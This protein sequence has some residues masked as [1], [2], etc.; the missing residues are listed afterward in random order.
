M[1][2]MTFTDDTMLGGIMNTKE[3]QDMLL[4]NLEN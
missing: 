4:E 1:V 2:L 3:D